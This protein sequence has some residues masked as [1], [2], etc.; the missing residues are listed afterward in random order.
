MAGT[1]RPRVAHYGSPGAHTEEAALAIFGA[2]EALPCPTFAAIFEAVAEGVAEFGVVAVENSQAGSINDTYDLLLTHRE[3]V[4]IQGEYDLHVHHHLLALPG[5]TLDAITVAFSHPQALAQT[6]GFLTR[7]GIAGEISGDTAGSAR[8]VR[9]EGARGQAAV[10]GHRAAEL[11]GLE[12]LAEDIEDN[13]HNFTKFLVLSPHNL[14]VF[15]TTFALPPIDQRITKRSLV[16]SVPNTPG[17]LY[18]A[19]GPI[20][21]NGL[22]LTKIES[23]PARERPWDY[24]FYADVEGDPNDPRYH[25]ALVELQGHCIF[26]TVLGSYHVLGSARATGAGE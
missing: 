1:I 21:T 16:F 22:N 23:R 6:H 24:H 17:S 9:E 25:A 3:A 11:H 12:V 7:H 2:I 5:A 20:A 10:A 19:L 13:P 4:A 15:P 14:R 26:L 8:R 18:A